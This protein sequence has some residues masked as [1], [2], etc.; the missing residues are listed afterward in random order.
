MNQLQKTF[1]NKLR[2]SQSSKSD[3]DKASHQTDSSTPS[4][5]VVIIGAGIAGLA[6]AELLCA[7]GHFKVTIL[8]GSNRIGGRIYTTDLDDKS[9]LEIGAQ[10][11]HGHKKNPIYKLAKKYGIKVYNEADCYNEKSLHLT[12]RGDV[13]RTSKAIKAMDFYEDI[14]N[15]S[16]NRQYLNELPSNSNNVGS[17]IK[18]KLKEKL[19]TIPNKDEQSLLASIYSCREAIECVISACDS[20]Q[21]LH[22]QDFGDYIELTGEDKEF[23]NGFSEIPHKIAQNIP[24]DVLH[25]NNRV[26]KIRRNSTDTGQDNKNG[27]VTIECTNAKTYKADFVI[28]TVSLGVLK[29]EAADLFDSS[30]SEKKLKVIDRMGFGLTDKL[31]LRYSKPFWKHRDFSYFFYWDD[32]DYKNSRGKGIQL[33]EGEE[34]LRSIVNI[35]TVRLNSDTLVI[36]ISGECARVMEKLSKKDISNSITRVLQKFTGI[37]NLPE[38][39]DVI[40]TKWFSDPLFCGS[41]SYISTSSCSDD[42][43]TLAEPE[44][45]EDGCPLILFAGEATHRNFYSTTHGAYLTGQREATRIINLINSNA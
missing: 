12:E 26:Q 32:E 16:T 40:Q 15:Q 14:L 21:D 22:L 34:W 19:S 7:D 42:V 39:Y 6:A 9:K 41:Y 23:K 20:L 44:V 35:E 33:A 3:A 10:F 30:L 38:P 17:Y 1:R 31:Y 11:I 37:S 43:D 45:D 8:E 18:W 27:R 29:K 13:V 28:C 2:K 5:D 24:T 25:L 4:I 36:W